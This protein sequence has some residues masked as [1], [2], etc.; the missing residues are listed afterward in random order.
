MKR[1][2]VWAD[3]VCAWAY[4]GRQRLEKAELG[5]DVEVV[6]RP[7]QIDPMAPAETEPLDEALRD[8]VA[9]G[10]LRACHPTLTPEENRERVSLVAAEERLGPRWGAVWRPNTFDA[11]RVIALAY[12]RGGSALQDAVVE[13]L[14]RAHFTEGADIGDR[15]TLA[16]LAAE[17]GLDGMARALASGRGTAEVR[18]Q[19]L[20]GKAI[21]VATSPTFVV[22]RSAV[23]GAQSPE[24]L[25]DLVRQAVPERELPEEVTCLR[26]AEAL[27]DARDPLG[28]LEM[29]RP[30]LDGH[31]DDPAV[32]LLAARAYFGSAQLGRARQTL[33]SLLERAPGDHYAR[34]LLGRT[35]ERSNRHAEALPHL[36]MAAAMSS[37]PEYA[38]A[39]RRAQERAGA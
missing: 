15:A 27:L 33:E 21:G 2:E 13:R 6:W 39:V 17:A 24:V 16:A 7:Y 38:G 19:L 18:S 30:L 1:I 3:M 26:H 29:L 14:M 20:R 4:I 11:H 35:L 25:R 9:E 37:D 31:G 8:P 34:F 36:R 12:E 32:R 28:A 10:A 5:E 23:S 22:G